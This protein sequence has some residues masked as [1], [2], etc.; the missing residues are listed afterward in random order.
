LLHLPVLSRPRIAGWIIATEKSRPTV[1]GMPSDIEDRSAQQILEYALEQHAN[2]G[3]SF[4][5]A[6][7]VVL[8][9][10]AVRIRP[11]V[12]VFALDTGRLHA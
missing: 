4:S 1:T 11:E 6:E 10:M 2:I 12:D 8:I 3:I 7:D 9:D 5:G